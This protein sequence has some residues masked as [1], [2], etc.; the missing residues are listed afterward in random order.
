MRYSKSEAIDNAVIELTRRGW[1]VEK[2]GKHWKVWSPQGDHRFIVPGTPSD[3]RAEKNWLSDVRRKLRERN[4]DVSFMEP[5][6]SNPLIRTPIVIREEP[7]IIPAEPRKEWL[8]LTDDDEPMITKLS[9]DGKTYDE[10]AVILNAMGYRI[11]ISDKQLTGTNIGSYFSNRKARPSRKA[12]VEKKPELKMP[13][14][15]KA[16]EPPKD[17]AKDRPLLAMVMEIVS[18]NLNDDMKE[19]LLDLAISNLFTRRGG[20]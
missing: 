19:H 17:T 10:I 14:P 6:F 13:P 8:R 5:K 4:E 11:R 20:K 1:K 16:V 18:S 7:K 2:G 9:E 3:F 12:Q 15:P